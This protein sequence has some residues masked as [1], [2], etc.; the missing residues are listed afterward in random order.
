MS[1][2]EAIGLSAETSEMQGSR[3]E[4][5]EMT[6]RGFKVQR[7]FA[8]QDLTD[9]ERQLF[10]K[11]LQRDPVSEYV[12]YYAERQDRII[13]HSAN[14][15]ERLNRVF[16]LDWLRDQLLMPPTA[17]FLD[18]GCG[19]ASAGKYIA[20]YLDAGR[21]TGVDISAVSIDEG[22]RILEAH[23][24]EA[25]QPVLH[26]IPD[27][28]LSALGDKRFDIIWA[29][30]VFTHLPPEVIEDILGRLRVHL[31]PG[32]AIY[33]S[34]TLA[35]AGEG[36]LQVNP[37]NWFQEPAVL[38]ACGSAAGYEMERM[39]G[40]HHPYGIPERSALMRFLPREE[41]DAARR[42]ELTL[43]GF[44]VLKDIYAADAAGD[45]R[46]MA[47]AIFARPDSLDP[48]LGDS[49]H[50]RNNALARFDDI[51]RVLMN[52]RMLTAIQRI[53]GDGG[54]IL[55]VNALCQ[56]RY[57]TWHKDVHGLEKR[58][59]DFH[60][61]TED[62]GLYTVIVYQ[63]ESS[64]EQ[65]GGL[66]IIPGSHRVR[67]RYSYEAGDGGQVALGELAYDPALVRTLQSS[68]CDVIIFDVRCDHRGSWPDDW[69]PHRSGTRENKEIRKYLFSFKIMK[70]G[71]AVADYM[72]YFLRLATELPD[73]RYLWET[74]PPS[75]LAQRCAN[76]GLC[77]L[78]PADFKAQ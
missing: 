36:V 16:Q 53:V 20:D 17:D 77:Y 33:A 30:S 56:D 58:G 45:I 63:Q 60:W 27:G 25:K 32:G 14:T 59:Y 43:R 3:Q 37:H 61:K 28:D 7:L 50:V 29:Q 68:P 44:T 35:E 21:Y 41:G 47:E 49:T 11:Y 66:D 67:D 48:S 74:R 13:S 57:S 22:R 15:F 42:H 34:A 24:L 51:S 65:G 9:P 72:G 69:G 31:K 46:Q 55:P 75:T 19:T 4:R 52:D 8:S 26:V 54:Y 10:D 2:S 70:Q 73:F 5:G 71:P 6:Y 1:L 12:R 39:E 38:A 18:Y 62:L 64:R 78:D 76:F 23:G 40:W